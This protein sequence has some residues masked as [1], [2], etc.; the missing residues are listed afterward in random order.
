MNMGI[1]E[2]RIPA[3]METT[4]FLDEARLHWTR[5]EHII[6]DAELPSRYPQ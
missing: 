2:G 5:L 4:P 3:R 6:H 1:F